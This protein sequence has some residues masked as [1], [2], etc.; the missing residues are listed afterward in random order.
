MNDRSRTLEIAVRVTLLI[1]KC[2]KYRYAQSNNQ[3]EMPQYYQIPKLNNHRQIS[4]IRNKYMP[5]VII[6][7]FIEIFALFI[8]HTRNVQ[9]NDE[10]SFGYEIECFNLL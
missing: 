8:R 3:H 10:K 5:D 4:L 6:T 9:I 1:C 2:K 7:L